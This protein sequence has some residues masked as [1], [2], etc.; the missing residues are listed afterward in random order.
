MGFIE[1]NFD[2]K[3]YFMIDYYLELNIDFVDLIVDSYLVHC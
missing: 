1:N 2:I 3:T